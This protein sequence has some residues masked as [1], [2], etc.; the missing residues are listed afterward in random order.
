MLPRGVKIFRIEGKGSNKSQNRNM[1]R[2][3]A[4]E[5]KVVNITIVFYPCCVELNMPHMLYTKP[6]TSQSN[7]LFQELKTK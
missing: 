3:D 4:L 1:M 2:E 5:Y 7:C 6:P